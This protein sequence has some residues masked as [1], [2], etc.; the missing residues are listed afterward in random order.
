MVRSNFLMLGSSSLFW[1][2]KWFV[3]A[4]PFLLRRRPHGNVICYQ[5]SWTC[6]SATVHLPVLGGACSFVVSFC[7]IWFSCEIAGRYFPRLL[8]P[9]LIMSPVNP[10]D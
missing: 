10:Y 8:L 4:A 5:C 3:P 6:E 9:L 2:S 1:R 7:C